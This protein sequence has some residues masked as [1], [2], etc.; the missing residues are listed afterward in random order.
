M[1][2]LPLYD[3]CYFRVQYSVSDGKPYV[4][5]LANFQDDTDDGK[6]WFIYTK[7]LASTENPKL[8]EQSKLINVAYQ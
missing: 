2:F 4:I 1:N 3:I 7:P 8:V 6:F 5:G